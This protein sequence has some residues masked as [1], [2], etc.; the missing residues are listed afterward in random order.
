MNKHI[1][2]HRQERKL[3]KRLKRHP[4]VKRMAVHEG[5]IDHNE[6]RLSYD[7]LLQLVIPDDVSTFERPEE[8][9]VMV[10]APEM[11]EN[12]RSL[13][14]ENVPEHRVVTSLASEFAEIHDIE[15]NIN[16]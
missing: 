7:K 8:E 11:K 1:R 6:N 10:E 5:L 16:E 12:V 2:V 4:E 15:V 3:L 9:M 14:G 13:A